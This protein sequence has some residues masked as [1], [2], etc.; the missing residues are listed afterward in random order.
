M[1]YNV[2]ICHSATQRNMARYLGTTD[3]TI[4]IKTVIFGLTST[5]VSIPLWLSLNMYGA[6]GT[7]LLLFF[8]HLLATYFIL[9]MSLMKYP[10]SI[11]SSLS[12]LK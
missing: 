1:Y 6:E 5:P 12:L 11:V 8:D 3:P 10:I 9:L 4:L 2:L 7:F